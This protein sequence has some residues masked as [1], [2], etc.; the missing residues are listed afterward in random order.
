MRSLGGGRPWLLMEQ[1]ASLVD[2]LPRNTLKRPGQMRLWSY[3]ALARGA[4]GV[5]FFQWRA[6]RFGAHKFHGAMVPHSG[7]RSRIWREVKSLGI[8]LA[9]L[10]PVLGSKVSAS[11]AVVFDWESWWALELETA[12]PSVEVRLLDQL[13]SYFRPLHAANIAV[14]FIRPDGDLSGYRLVLVPNLYLVSDAGAASL[15]RFV[16]DG[17]ALVMSFMTGIVDDRDHIR[18]GGYAGAF[19]DVLGLRVEEFDAYP[20][21]RTNRILTLEG[22]SYHCDLWSDL[23]ELEGAEAIA[24]YGEDFYA[25][26]PAV[27]RHRFGRGTSYYL[28]T[29]P[30]ESYMAALLGR[31]CTESGVTPTLAA[32]AGVEVVRRWGRGRSF[33]FVLNHNSKPTEVRLPGPARDLLTGEDREGRIVLE[34]LGVAVLE[35]VRSTPRGTPAAEGGAPTVIQRSAR[36]AGRSPRGGS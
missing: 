7:T 34:P 27:A 10:D 21:E 32:P 8:E 9:R 31:V 17:G 15:E 11:A 4:D 5:L 36:G 35:E 16:A 14:D 12:K 26:V 33:L 29:R 2:W 1:T 22:K 23:I 30:E 6:Q 3:Q 18:E 19:G 24:T 13:Q 28:G 20:P 25:G